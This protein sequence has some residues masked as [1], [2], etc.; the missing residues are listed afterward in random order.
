MNDES[1]F[2]PLP[3]TAWSLVNR[4]AREDDRGSREA[5]GELLRRYFPALRAYV[6][7]SRLVP[8]DQVEDVLQGFVTDKLLRRDL[9]ASADARR[10]KFRS[11]LLAALHRYIASHHRYQKAR[12]RSPEGI[13]SLDGDT[14]HDAVDVASQSDPLDAAWACE[15]LQ[16]A[17]RQMQEQ[18]TAAERTDIWSLFEARLLAPAI[19]GAEPMPYDQLVAKHALGT[20]RQACNVLGTAKRM[21]ARVLRSVI[22]EYTPEEEI[23]D[24]IRELQSVLLRVDLQEIRV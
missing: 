3:E 21:F 7:R 9:I 14:R 1:K 20:P 8:R 15:V 16:Q 6:V 13:V 17:I 19:S 2:Q 4:A 11:L 24:E 10:G 23:E 12:K 22:A 5:L 18:C